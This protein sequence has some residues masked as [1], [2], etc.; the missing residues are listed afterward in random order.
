MTSR[1]AAVVV[2]LMLIGSGAFAGLHMPPAQACQLLAHLPGMLD[3]L[4]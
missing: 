2:A 4:L 3:A 1:I